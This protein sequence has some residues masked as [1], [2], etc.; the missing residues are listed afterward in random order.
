[1]NDI[2]HHPIILSK[3]PPVQRRFR[4]R[5]FSAVRMMN[6]E[7]GLSQR[8]LLYCLDKGY[9]SL[10]RYILQSGS[11]DAR[12]R[13]PEGRTGLMYCCFIDRD[14]W[15]QNI[16]TMLLQYG[17]KI[18]DQDRR[19]LNALHYAII[20]ERLILIQ[21][22]LASF[23]CDLNRTR[24]IHGNTFL[25]YACST[26]NV[27]VVRLIL[28]AVNRY[29]FDLNVKNNAGSTAYDIACQLKYENCQDLLRNALLARQNEHLPLIKSNALQV[30]F[31]SIIDDDHSSIHQTKS[32]ISLPGCTSRPKKTRSRVGNTLTSSKE[33]FLQSS[34]VFIDPIESRNMTLKHNETLD[35][36]LVIQAKGRADFA[37]TSF[38]SPSTIFS[39]SSS[40]WRDDVSKVF[41]QLQTY[42]TASYRKSVHPPLNTELSCEVY[43]RLYGIAGSEGHDC[44]NHQPLSSLPMAT[45]Q[46]II[47]RRRSSSSSIKSLLRGKK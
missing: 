43:E 27:D 39:N 5:E 17:A 22:Y 45:S 8:S 41:N 30:S 46:K 24:D 28:S 7:R 21:R 35:S 6:V 29:S 42:K 1:M 32:V 20:T 31:E 34:S 16:A 9:F 4:S 40:T 33:N 14:G 15:A 12:E 3:L 25:H 37:Q 2:H 23:E 11:G 26:G 18:E 38:I 10:V 44:S 47:H 19:G 36:S 13:D